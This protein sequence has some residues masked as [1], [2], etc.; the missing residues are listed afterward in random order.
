MLTEGN[1]SCVPGETIVFTAVSAATGSLDLSESWP[2]SQRL[3]CLKKA[4]SG[5]SSTGLW[6]EGV[7]LG[8]TQTQTD[9]LRWRELR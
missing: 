8:S 1:P 4:R 6:R 2:W 7:E 5:R 9:R 3:L